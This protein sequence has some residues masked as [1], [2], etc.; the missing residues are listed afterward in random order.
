VSTKNISISEESRVLGE[1][2]PKIDSLILEISKQISIDESLEDYFNGKISSTNETNLLLSYFILEL[3]WLYEIIRRENKKIKLSKEITKENINKDIRIL[4]EKYGF[5]I[6]SEE[7]I[8]LLSKEL[9]EK[10]ISSLETIE[11]K[12]SK[13]KIDIRGVIFQNLL[14]EELRKVTGSYHTRSDAAEILASI[15]INDSKSTVMDLS[16]GSGKLLVASNHRINELH[17]TKNNTLNQIFGVELMQIPSCLAVINLFLENPDVKSSTNIANSDSLH[18]EPDSQISMLKSNESKSKLS[19]VDTIIMNPPFTR[20][21]SLEKNQKDA[22]ETRFSKYDIVDKRIGLHGYFILLGNEFLKNNGTMALVLPAT[23][24]R[25]ESFTKLR[26]FLVENFQIKYL[27][28]SNKS[29]SFSYGSRF[30]EILLVIKKT[31]PK[32]SD[33]TR[34]GVLNEK[35]VIGKNVKDIISSLTKKSIKNSKGMELIDI[36][37]SVFSQNYQNLFKFI[38]LS[39]ENV[40][41]TYEKIYSN[42]KKLTKFKEYCKVHDHKLIRGWETLRSLHPVQS[43]Y[44]LLNKDDT[45]KKSPWYFL[46]QD[47]TN[48]AITNSQTQEKL[49]IPNSSIK[50]GLRRLGKINTISANGKLDYIV[51]KKFKEI[52][53]FL[54]EPIIE[55][56]NEWEKITQKKSSKLAFVRRFSL[57]GKSMSVCAIVSDEEFTPTQTMTIITYISEDDAKILA[58]WLNSSIHILQMIVERVETEGAYMELPEWAMKELFIINPDILTSIQRKKILKIYEKISNVEFPPLVQ[59]LKDGFTARDEIDQ[60]FLDI[61]EIKDTKIKDIQNLVREEID[62]LRSLVK[63]ND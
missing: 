12:Y 6:F 53:K 34:I 19:K 27:I 47:Q 35:P 20:Q 24:L 22:L 11:E 40:F 42:N 61:L 45:D 39:K 9:I 13:N 59:Q 46:K 33:K 57:G 14:P 28:S 58:L 15:S 16:C 29:S 50:F 8:S 36:D 4:R 17:K 10:T 7:L 49:K 63:S 21:E 55:N 41:L 1:V 31:A 62:D 44:I 25:I 26:K 23:V 18:L 37:N 60:V 3:L 30:R 52:S 2:K 54:S 56:F 48:I 43:D 51:C 32:K 38:S 5:K